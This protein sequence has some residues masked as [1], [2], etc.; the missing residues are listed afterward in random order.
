MKRL[1]CPLFFFL[2]ALSLACNLVSVPGPPQAT[3]PPEG[4]NPPTGLTSPSP[5]QSGSAAPVQCPDSEPSF[6]TDLDVRQPTSLSEP[7]PRVPFRDPVFGRCLVRVTDRLNDKSP[8]DSSAGLKNEY[9]RVQSFNADDTRLLVRGTEATWYLYNAQTLQPLGQLPLDVE[10]RWSATDPNVIYYSSETRLM[11]YNIASQQTSL[12]H[13]FANDFPGQTLAAVWSKYEGSPSVDGRYWGFMAEDQDWNPVA[14]LVYDQQTDAVIAKRDVRGVPGVEN[15]DNAYISPLGNY[16]IA[17]FAD[18]YCESGQLGT[19]A[20]PCGYMVY[21]RNIQNG[22]G[23]LRISGHMDLALDAQGR[24]VVVYQ[25]IDTDNISMLDLATGAVTPLW[26][27]DFS[28]TSI[29]LHI[30]GRAFDRPGW[31]VVS[32]HD[33]DVAS[34]TWIDDSVFLVELKPNGRVV[35]LAHTHSLVDENQEHDYWAEPHASANRDLTRVLFTTNWERSGTEQVETYLIFVPTEAFS[36]TRDSPPNGNDSRPDA[37]QV[38]TNQGFVPSQAVSQTYYVA[39]TGNDSNPGT[40]S[41][42]WRTIQKAANTLVAGEMVYIRGGTYREQVVPQNSGSAGNPIVYA[43]YPGETVTIDGANVNL[44][45]WDGLFNIINKAYIRVTGLRIL[46]AGPNPHNLGI[47]SDGS[48]HVV[49]EN[50]FVSH[51]ND[52]GIGAWNSDNIVV[53][54]NEVEYACLSGFNESISVGGTDVFE[55]SHNRV[56]HSQK[57]GITLKDGSSNGKAF[58]NEVYNL[59]NVGIYVDAW[60]KHTYNIEVYQNIVHNIQ[61][62]GFAL[63]SEMGGLLEN[64]RLYNNLSYSNRSTGI[65]LTRNGDSTTHPI[66]NIAIV[67]NTVTGNGTDWGGGIAVDSY[68]SVNVVVSNNLVSDNL[69]FQIVVDPL[70]PGAQVSVDHNLI[71]GFRDSEGETRGTNFVEGDPRFADPGT[72]NF[73]LQ[74]ASPAIN[75]GDNATL[76][77]GVT[78]DLD[79]NPR[80]VGGT[81]DL[82]AYEFQ[83]SAATITFRSQAA[84]DGWILESSEATNIGGTMDNTAAVF[85]LGDDRLDRQFRAILSFN[86]ASLPDNA[87]LAKVTLKLKLQGTIGMNPFQTHGALWADVNTGPFSGNPALQLNDFRAASSKGGV[88]F[89]PKTPSNGWYVKTWTSGIFPYINKTGLTQFRLRFALDDNDDRGA[90]YLKFYSGDATWADRP[91]LVV[92]YYSGGAQG[93]QASK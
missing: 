52:S 59:D 84:Y 69:S 88:G 35:R 79:G 83:G 55:V 57:E 33:G 71:D 9:S 56:H 45:E 72:A 34:H 41:Q 81:V 5:P 16:F 87:V 11:S 29:G 92:E 19:D 60:D 8:D 26:P 74:S 32:T 89:F 66:R 86:T 75:A 93:Q 38:R 24:E 54:N 67:N 64:V 91:Q 78:T 22:R 20:V 14:F 21:D 44:P 49:I 70:I 90:D 13:E 61:D 18:Y 15:V 43:A 65:G 62:D 76:P 30:S 47:L 17:D 1:F 51:T 82:G 25:D 4:E 39:P 6:V 80:L 53:T 46:N 73:R 31:A 48:S 28:Y 2:L 10:P 40:Q 3:E 27:I 77:T 7:A 58:G 42:P 85:V 12:V 63:A 68:E 37:G 50:N 36:Q 23:L